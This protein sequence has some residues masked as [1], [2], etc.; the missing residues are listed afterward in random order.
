ML[1]GVLL[2]SSR[3]FVFEDWRLARLAGG[4]AC[5]DWLG[6][7]IMPCRVSLWAGAYR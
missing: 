4:G 1:T 2:G 6:V 7:C 3:E 5:G